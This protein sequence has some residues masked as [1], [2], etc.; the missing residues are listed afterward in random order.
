MGASVFGIIIGIIINS[1]IAIPENT[2]PGVDFSSKSILQF[3]IILLGS[4]LSFNQ[5]T[6]TGASS[7][8]VMLFTIP[9]AFIIAFGAGKLLKVD[10]PLKSLIGAG[11]AI[12]GGSAIAAVSSVIDADEHDISYSISTIFLFNV[13]AVMI[14]PP[15]GHLFGLS[16]YGFGLLSGTAINDTS[17]VVAAGYI[18][19]NTAGD[20]AAIVKLTRTTMIIPVSLAFMAYTLFTRKKG[21]ASA[22][23]LKFSIVKIFP[24]FILGFI[25]NGFDKFDGDYRSDLFIRH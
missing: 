18:F 13:I 24:W 22:G 7:F 12:C 9:A 25:R 23:D 4:T 15:L 19:S 10:T 8:F 1:L 6:K 11:T 16:D 3:S 17:S 5:I 2:G 14:F 21:S 20:F